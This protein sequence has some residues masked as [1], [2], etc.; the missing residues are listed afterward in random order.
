M[1]LPRFFDRRRCW[2][3]NR[4][5]LAVGV[6]LHLYVSYSIGLSMVSLGKGRNKRGVWSVREG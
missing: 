1:H 5:A 3:R 2:L 4:C 6:D